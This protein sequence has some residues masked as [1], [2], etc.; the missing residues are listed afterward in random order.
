MPESTEGNPEKTRYFSKLAL[1]NISSARMLWAGEVLGK[2]RYG[3]DI[4]RNVSEHTLA[5]TAGCSVLAEALGLPQLSIRKLEKAALLHDWDKKFQSSGLREIDRRFDRG[6]VT[7]QDR[8]RLKQVL[9]EES[10][11]HSEEGMRKASI[12]E[13]VIKLAT[14]DGHGS[15]PRMM[16]PDCTLEEKILHYIGSITNNDQIVSLDERMDKLE[17]DPKYLAMNEYGRKYPWTHG[18]TF[19]EVQRDVGHQIEAELAKRLIDSGKLSSDW[20]ANLRKDPKELPVF[21]R[22]KIA[23]KYAS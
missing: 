22:E 11:R 1:R 7:E 15:L 8:G 4:W 6:E 23:E 12:A 9:F 21:I 2:N 20:Q 18:R 10:E 19:Y 5:Q 13:D 16:E 17:V 3:L 14:A